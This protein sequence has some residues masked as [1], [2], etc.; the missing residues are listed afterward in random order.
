VSVL[1]NKPSLGAQWLSQAVINTAIEKNTHV[2]DATLIVCTLPPR[3]LP[4]RSII[5]GALGTGAPAP[6]GGGMVRPRLSS[7]SGN[8]NFGR[9]DSHTKLA[10]QEK[11]GAQTARV[12]TGV[13]RARVETSGMPGRHTLTAADL[14]GSALAPPK[15]LKSAGSNGF[16]S[17]LF[18]SSSHKDMSGT[19]T[20]HESDTSTGSLDTRMSDGLR[21]S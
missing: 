8:P 4:R 12:L 19:A 10:G 21:V 14:G 16:L 20:P 13:E 15:A 9:K 5:F 6:V 3:R 18:K 7:T 17:K 2:D 1:K 11:S